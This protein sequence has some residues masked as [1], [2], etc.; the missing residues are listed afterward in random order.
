[1]KI[2]FISLG[3]GKNQVNCEQ[4]LWQAYEAGH[5]IALEAEDCDVAVL[6]TCGFLQEAK[7]EALEELSRLEALKEAGR[8]GKIIVAGCMAQRYRKDLNE[9]CPGADG[10]L[11]CG[12]YEDVVKV[13][14]EVYGG[15][16]VSHF[17]D[18]NAP[19]PETNRVVISSDHWAYLRIA[20][21]CDNH[22][23]YCVIPSIRGKFRSRPKEAIL[24][25]AKALAADGIQELLVVAQDITRYGTD[26]YEKRALSDLLH[27]LCQIQGIH[28]IRLH[29]LYP[30]E[31]DEALVETVASEEKIVKYLDIPIQHI[32]DPVLKAMHRRG[33]G[34]EIRALF[35]KLRE[36]IPGIALRTSIIC[37]HPGETEEDFEELC[38]FLREFRIERAGIFPYSPEEGSLAA[39]MEHQV[40]EEEK[41]R[42]LAL[43]T[44]IQ[45][46]AADHWS[47][48]QVG[49]TVEVLC[50][51][52]DEESGF[53]LGRSGAESPG[54]DGVIHLM[55]DFTPGEFALVT[56]TALRDGE[57]YGKRG[58]S[59]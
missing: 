18:I 32:S 54:I 25:E 36:R 42:R 20:E 26:L 45:M 13:A 37:G 48:A 22:C 9:L 1:M 16:F 10:F 57:L 49:K 11:G 5:E 51:D 3:C 33:T 8:L 52:F 12:G 4:M 34:G 30:N 6:N 58:G 29:Y 23:A 46:E 40:E 2:G 41:R 21:G 43:L 35:Q 44:E 53:F 31:V 47:R 38:T 14:E 19:V 56:I 28:W 15:G 27:D 17:E 24:E 7:R 59:L 39:T 50:E 55:G